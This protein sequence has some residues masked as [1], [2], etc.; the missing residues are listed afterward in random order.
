MAAKSTTF[1]AQLLLLEAMLSDGIQPE[2]KALSI[3]LQSCYREGKGSAATKMVDRLRSA[4]Y[5]L[6]EYHYSILVRIYGEDHKPTEALA[7]LREAQE[8]GIAV[9][10]RFYA[11]VIDALASQISS[12]RDKVTPA[13]EAEDENL[14]ATCYSLL[15]EAFSVLDITGS[16]IS[17]G[18]V[19]RHGVLTIF[20]T[21]MKPASR[22]GD[23]QRVKLLVGGLEGLNVPFDNITMSCVVQA[24]AAAGK[25]SDAQAE[26]NGYIEKGYK[27]NGIVACVIIN[28]LSR[29]GRFYESWLQFVEYCTKIGIP[30]VEKMSNGALREIEM[31]PY[32]ADYQANPRKY[33]H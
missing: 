27:P 30:V 15:A 32:A 18:T 10:L 31:A 23:Y 1:Q 5:P 8:A 11:T 4:A 29:L 25:L 14:A 17:R 22:L 20:H 19:D 13:Q 33:F 26:F 12:N 16:S 6:N 2:T 3:F 9:D 28:A 21:A 24:Y 7:I